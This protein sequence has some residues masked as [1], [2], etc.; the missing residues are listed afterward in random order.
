[1]VTHLIIHVNDNQG[2]PNRI[3]NFSIYTLNLVGVSEIDPL[4]SRIDFSFRINC[5]RTFRLQT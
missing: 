3:G 5:P 1:M 4:F 2:N